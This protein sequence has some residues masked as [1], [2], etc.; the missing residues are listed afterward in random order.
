VFVLA[1]Q[2]ERFIERYSPARHWEEH[3]N[4]IAEIPWT[5]PAKATPERVSALGDTDWLMLSPVVSFLA[6]G[7]PDPPSDMHPFIANKYRIR[8]AKT[9]FAAAGKSHLKLFGT[10]AMGG[11]PGQIPAAIFAD[12]LT[13]TGDGHGFEADLNAVSDE[14]FF[15]MRDSGPDGRHWRGVRIERLSL[16]GWLSKPTGQAQSAR[17]KGGR[18]PVVDWQVVER[19]AVHIRQQEGPFDP[20]VP[21]W[22]CQA[23]LEERLLAFC[24]K[25]FG[26]EPG[27]ATLR[28]RIPLFLATYQREL[29]T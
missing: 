23:R 1:V 18:K 8:A 17:R 19:E 12:A 10:C 15:R 25:R 28:S 7:E 4:L 2:I 20:A 24:Q 13:L 6:F 14:V 3:G 9:L 26:L 29:E 11:L 5:L 16:D 21:E 22:N 27:V